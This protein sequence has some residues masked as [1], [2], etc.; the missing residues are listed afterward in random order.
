[1][2]LQHDLDVAITF[3]TW[4]DP[5]FIELIDGC[6]DF[7]TA[8]EGQW[9][10]PRFQMF[11]KSKQLM[12][13]LNKVT[14]ATWEQPMLISTRKRW[15][16]LEPHCER[17]LDLVKFAASESFEK[18]PELWNKFK[19]MRRQ[20]DA[21]AINKG[22][23][24][25]ALLYKTQGGADMV[26][27]VAR[28]FLL[29]QEKNRDYFKALEEIE[30]FL[31]HKIRDDY[32]PSGI[33]EMGR[34]KEEKRARKVSAQQEDTNNSVKGNDV[35]TKIT[36][37]QSEEGDK[38]KGMAIE[39]A[40][41]PKNVTHAKTSPRSDIQEQYIQEESKPPKETQEKNTDATNPPM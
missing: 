9:D 13:E 21:R 35:G 1:M 18:D 40:A 32:K 41:I 5:D 4:S 34:S 36:T 29:G 6:V 26:K 38:Q 25:D 10:V 15:A 7:I 12:A 33:S 30:R 39:E 11:K 20:L 3:Y 16:L 31:W 23:G 19:A 17:M 37:Q 22:G 14:D 28:L 2:I 24:M 8:L 27:A